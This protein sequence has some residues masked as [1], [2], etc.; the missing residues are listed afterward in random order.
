[1]GKYRKARNQNLPSWTWTGWAGSVVMARFS[2]GLQA[3]HVETAFELVD[4]TILGF[5]EFRLLYFEILEKQI[6]SPIIHISSP[7]LQMSDFLRV[8]PD[9]SGKSKCKFEMNDGYYIKIGFVCISELLID[10]KSLR[11]VIMRT[12]YM[13]NYFRSFIFFLVGHGVERVSGAWMHNFNT[14]LSGPDGTVI[15]EANHQDCIK[16]YEGR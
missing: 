1:M 5:H 15:T 13:H 16:R 10:E 4:G 7:T 14:I 11:A 9:D 8:I 6:G 3:L 12:D 2:R